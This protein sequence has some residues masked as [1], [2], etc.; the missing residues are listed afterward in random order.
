MAIFSQSSAWPRR[1]SDLASVPLCDAVLLGHPAGFRVD[2]V[3]NP[4]MADDAG[5]PQAVD[6]E[7]ALRQW[8][9][10][11]DGYR[12]AGL[13]VASIADDGAL[14]DLCFTANPSMVLPVPNG[15]PEVWLAHM[16]HQ[17]RRPEVALH[18]EFFAK[19]NCSLRQMPPHI[20]SF[21]GCGDG[22]LHP[23]RF[24]LHAG[25]GPRTSS[26]AWQELA[27]TH[28]EL[29]ILSY[30]LVDPRFYHL[31]TALAPLNERTALWVPE[32]FTAQGAELLQAA[33]PDAIRLPLAESLAFAANAH[34]PDG[35]HVL[36]DSACQATCTVLA[37]RGF[38]P[39]PIDTSEFR[40]S[41]GSVFCLKQ[42]FP[43]SILR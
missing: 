2:E 7:R 24:L 8:Q 25:V 41:G 21:E 10:L 9:S 19:Q 11:V 26:A 27:N 34:C 16:R 30:E 18:R 42:A 3:H 4:H 13:Q 36:I 31:D 29:D 22:V 20:D 35:Q 17:S 33:F 32:A 38:T 23:C 1:A 6:G 14:A 37:E 39:V 12:A 43:S 15:A 28:T 5:L 40:K